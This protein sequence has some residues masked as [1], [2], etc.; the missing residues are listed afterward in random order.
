[1]ITYKYQCIVCEEYVDG[2]FKMG[3]APSKIKC[4]CGSNA[5]RVYT[6]PSVKISNP[7]SEARV[8]RGKGR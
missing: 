6:A 3:K 1:M 5:E 7:V 8:G 2:D 4:L